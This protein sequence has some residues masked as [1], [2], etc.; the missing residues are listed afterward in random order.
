MLTE[1]LLW[2]KKKQWEGGLGQEEMAALIVA[3]NPR[4]KFIV[5]VFRTNNEFIEG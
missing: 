3:V 1:T 5:E 2:T 4:V